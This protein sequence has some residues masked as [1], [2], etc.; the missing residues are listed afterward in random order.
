M[1]SGRPTAPPQMSTYMFARSPLESSGFCI[2]A[3]TAAPHMQS[4]LE[5]VAAA[6][7]DMLSTGTADLA[8]LASAAQPGPRKRRAV[9]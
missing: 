6:D 2:W 7:R 1:R 9:S 5:A 8:D 3:M 4:L